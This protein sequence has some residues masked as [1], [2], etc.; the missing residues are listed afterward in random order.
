MVSKSKGLFE[1]MI[2]IELKS[3]YNW[4]DE[5]IEKCAKGELKF[6]GPD[7][8]YTL[9]SSKGFSTTSLYEMV[10]AKKKQLG[11]W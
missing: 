9:F 7:S 3:R 8:L 5:A 10:V 4:I 6:S 1:A 2:E 11:L